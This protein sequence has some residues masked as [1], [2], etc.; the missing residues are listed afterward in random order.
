LEATT[1]IL[2]YYKTFVF[3]GS[4]VQRNIIARCR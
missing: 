2:T 1:Y 3:G 4:N